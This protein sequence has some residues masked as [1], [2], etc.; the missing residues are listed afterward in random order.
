MVTL[1]RQR[2]AQQATNLCWMA[3]LMH[4]YVSAIGVTDWENKLLPVEA[5]WLLGDAKYIP[6]LGD[7]HAT[8]EVIAYGEDLWAS[9]L[10]PASGVP[11]PPHTNRK[12]FMTDSYAAA[13]VVQRCMDLP[14]NS[15]QPQGT[16]PRVPPTTPHG[17]D[18][19]PEG[20]RSPIFQSNQLAKTGMDG[21][22]SASSTRSRPVMDD[23][24]SIYNDLHANA[25]TSL[26]TQM[27]LSA[28]A[29]QTEKASLA[30]SAKLL[31][32]EKEKAAKVLA[33]VIEEQKE[34]RRQAHLREKTQNDE[35]RS[36]S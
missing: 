6:D 32:M 18:P 36:S 15:V 20:L 26:S 4:G 27:M 28:L 25:D 11:R 22:R 29:L 19:K 24:N 16:E 33:I 14:L 21:P 17:T 10:I 1:Q 2:G 31:E 35:Y 30:H 12:R 34:E 8:A 9:Y 23:S 5:A 3:W 7:R 13:V